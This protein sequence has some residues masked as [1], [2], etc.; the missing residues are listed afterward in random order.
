VPAT[1]QAQETNRLPANQLGFSG[2]L[3]TDSG[4]S[5]FL[6]RHPV[7]AA[8][9]LLIFSF[10]RFGD[11]IIFFGG[12]GRRGGG[13]LS[14]VRGRVGRAGGGGAGVIL[15]ARYFGTEGDGARLAESVTNRGHDANIAV[16]IAIFLLRAEGDEQW[17]GDPPPPAP[18]EGA[19]ERSGTAAITS[20]TRPV[21]TSTIRVLLG[22][23][24]ES[25]GRPPRFFRDF[26]SAVAV[27]AVGAPL[28]PAFFG[29]ARGEVGVSSASAS[30]ATSAAAFFSTASRC[31]ANPTR[32]GGVILKNSNTRFVRDPFSSATVSLYSFG[33]TGPRMQSP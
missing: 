29:A 8:F 19:A 12:R 30:A 22:D 4:G 3:E 13:L 21:S 2:N 5:G 27:A 24:G 7:A 9:G 23:G 14:T 17:P 28:L 26:P 10:L 33:E 32:S 11:D 1:R 31:L 6:R 25:A 18:T 16:V 20:P 15:V